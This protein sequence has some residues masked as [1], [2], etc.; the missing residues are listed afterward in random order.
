MYKVETKS[1]EKNSPY[2]NYI[3][4]SFLF[5]FLA[6]LTISHFLRV[7][8][9]AKGVHFYFLFYAL[10]QALLE[11]LCFALIS[12]VLRRHF[13]SWAYRLYTGILFTLL[14]VHFVNYTLVRLL[15]VS[16]SYLFSFFFGEGLDHFFVAFA[17]INMNGAMIGL[18][19]GVIVLMPIAGI[20]FYWAT[21]K[22]SSKKPLRLSHGPLAAAITVLFV[23]LLISDVIIRPHLTTGLYEKYKKI[24][25]FG[26]TFLSPTP[27]L[28]T[29]PS[30]IQSVRS[31][32]S[33]QD[34]LAHDMIKTK[35][36]PDIYLFIIEALRRDFVD[37]NTAP[38]I[39]GF[40]QRHFAPLASYSNANTTHLSWFSIFH[41]LYPYFWTE[42]RDNW[43]LG[44]IPLQVL[45]KNGYHIHVYS[46][47]SLSYFDMDQ[48]VFGKQRYLA[49]S[50]HDFSSEH[51]LQPCERDQL[52]IDTMT[53]DT[54][55][56]HP[57]SL[58][59]VFLD[60]TH[61]E[62][63]VPNDFPQ[64]F[65]PSAASIQ[66]LSISKSSNQLELVKNRYRNAIHWVDY[67]LESF[68]QKL[69]SINK[70]DQAA[71]VLTGDHGEEFFED[72]A[73]F[74]GTHLNTW[75]T[76]VPIFFKIPINLSPHE[77]L[78]THVDIFPTLL[79]AL[80]GRADWSSYVDGQS[81]FS[82][83][84][85]N[86]A[87]SVQHNGLGVPYEFVMYNGQSKLFARFLNPPDIHSI[88]GIELLHIETENKKEAALSSESV[89]HQFPKAFEP[90][91]CPASQ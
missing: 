16:L 66:Y 42:V 90:L 24:V 67:L 79:H 88:A 73:I 4:F 38:G 3:F 51:S 9:P 87:L 76:R 60:S 41:S 12:L 74:H 2:I 15:D 44:S 72:G 57:P 32:A 17:A 89:Y 11:V 83:H 78:A 55:R 58:F 59:I 84:L 46:S 10:G 22:A 43:N 91:I 52:A 36:R 31:E 34:K 18:I 45:K 26:L 86:Y 64:P 25:P 77:A 50:V 19:I 27:C 6:T 40:S 85:W 13:P 8:S 54:L 70:Y 33:L 65:Q 39:T 48:I 82:D 80:T 53:A 35:S 20:V 56:P 1:H 75:Q 47:A 62:Y 49:D 28:L 61:S 21:Q 5:I 37:A 23:M 81:L 71:I 69:K 68:F 63:S 7:D 14:L 30:T 29:L